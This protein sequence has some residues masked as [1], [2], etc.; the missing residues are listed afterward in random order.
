MSVFVDVSS[1]LLR[2]MQQK[3]KQIVLGQKSNINFYSDKDNNR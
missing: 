2:V 1:I 3:I